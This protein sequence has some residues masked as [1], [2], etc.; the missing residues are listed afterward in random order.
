MPPPQQSPQRFGGPWSVVKLDR[1][2]AY[3][4]AFTKALR[5]KKFT[6]TY[7]DAFAGSGDFTPKKITTISLWDEEAEVSAIL[8]SARRAAAIEPKFD[9]LLFV[10]SSKQKAERLKQAV[11]DD[12]RCHVIHGDANTEVIRI[13]RRLQKLPMMRGVIF[14]DPFGNSTDWT[15]LEAIAGTQKLDVWYLCPLAGI[16][17]NAPH[18]IANLTEDKR[19][20]VTRILG[21]ADW[22]DHFYSTNTIPQKNLFD[23]PALPNARVLNV[24]GIEQFVAER[25][26]TI[27]P[28]VLSP[29]R[30]YGPTNAPM[31]SL[32]FAVSNPNKTAQ[33]V[34][35]DIAGH[36][37]KMR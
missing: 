21:T 27:F 17:R 25:L 34:A 19:E 8:G 26:K 14:L 16:Y 3:L 29:L 30:L 9:H 7:I 10:E 35:N 11:S 37:I 24:D 4:R 28:S 12:S 23:E 20:S 5:D 13:C 32:F 2:E 22:V 36:I 31:F 1:V 6:L 18:N 15:T 33:K